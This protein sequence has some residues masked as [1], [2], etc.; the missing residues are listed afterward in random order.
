MATTCAG[1]TVPGGAT[2]GAACT[3]N[4]GTWDLTCRTTHCGYGGAM[5]CGHAIGNDGVC[6]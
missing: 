3:A 4:E 5:H 6:Q 1:T 2:C